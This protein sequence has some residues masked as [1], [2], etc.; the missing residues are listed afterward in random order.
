MAGMTTPTPPAT[1]PPGWASG[2]DAHSAV[3]DTRTLRAMAHPMRVR[4]LGL[5]RQDGPSTAT[6]LADRLSINSGATSYHLRQLAGAGFV[7]EDE[8]RGTGRD[9]WWRAVHRST[10]FDPTAL[11][12]RDREVG[13]AYL[14]AVAT[15]YCERIQHATEAFSTLPDD[16]QDAW[17]MS[18]YRLRLTPA[19]LKALLGVLT[20]AIDRSRR[21]LPP[22][23][24][25]AEPGPVG[26]DAIILQLQ[27]FRVPAASDS[28]S[29]R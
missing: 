15:T 6:R 23:D 16:W 12:P 29:T 10:W 19:E 24:P 2:P 1:P 27:A 25:D 11:D 4:L 21:D 28:D 20:E 26:A 8:R 14:R 17:T 18:D 9:R 5:L 3:L 22:D 7:V 13:D